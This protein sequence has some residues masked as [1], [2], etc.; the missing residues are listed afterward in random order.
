MRERSRMLLHKVR[1]CEALT[2]AV[3]QAAA[4]PQLRCVLCQ[5]PLAL[6]AP[7]PLIKRQ[8]RL[9]RRQ[10][11]PQPLASSHHGEAVPEAHRLLQPLPLPRQGC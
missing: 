3:A 6:V 10:L 9:Q 4:A 11:Q 8:A 7:Q 5:L 1:A 2:K